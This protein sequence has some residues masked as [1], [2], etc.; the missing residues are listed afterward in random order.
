[1]PAT[2]TVGRIK[3]ID[4]ELKALS[5]VP[6]KQQ[7]LSKCPAESQVKSHLPPLLFQVDFFVY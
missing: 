2:R 5:G 3:F 6:G 1:M 4:L 7:V